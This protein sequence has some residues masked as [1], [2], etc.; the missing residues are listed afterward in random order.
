MIGRRIGLLTLL[1]LAMA[2]GAKAQDAGMLAPDQP[3]RIG[4]ALAVCTGVGLD[5]RQNPLWAEYPLKIE[6]AG[7]GGQ[8][9]GDVRLVLSQN[10]KMIAAVGCSGPWILFR[11][12]AG[13]YHVEA[14][15]EGRTISSSALVPASGQGRVI[16]RFPDLGGETG[17]QPSPQ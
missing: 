4:A 6:V 8:Y 1:G 9:L 5:A 17:P 11:L 2:S 13:R 15:T 3:T 14:R 16:L 7:R 10:D 12:P